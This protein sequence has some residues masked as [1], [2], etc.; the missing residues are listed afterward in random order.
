MPLIV[1]LLVSTILACAQDSFR[2]VERI[3]AVGD[4]H[5]GYNELVQALRS[6]SVID[7][8]GKWVG[9]KTHLVQTGDVLDRG[10][11][12]QKAMDLLMDLEKQSRRAGGRV[13]ALIGNHEAMNVYG[14]L[15]YV[16]PAEFEAFRSPQS[17][18]L[19]RE[20]AARATE[21]EPNRDAARTKW[22]QEHPMGWVEHR[23]AFEPSGTYGRWIVRHNAL[24]RVNDLL[25]LHGGIGPKYAKSSIT[26]L[27][28]R[29]QD[30]LRDLSKVQGGVAIDPEGPL[31]Y[32]GLAQDPEE[33]LAAHLE[34]VLRK[35]DVKRIIL[36]HTIQKEGIRTRFGGK[37]VLI[38]SGLS[39]VYGGPVECLV[40]EKD[41][42]RVAGANPRQ[43]K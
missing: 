40:I 3:V 35:Y 4:V 32:R 17:E 28:R 33:Q 11:E 22:E 24:V 31:W 38:D 16:S 36:G 39:A 12:S 10:P 7:E 21:N 27:N 34:E 37:V 26:E 8:G 15:R 25:F 43:L 18:K 2:S 5:G 20:Y 19:R 41:A 6:A 14:D 23:Q 9:G 29:I 30:E 13:H 42:L 1:L